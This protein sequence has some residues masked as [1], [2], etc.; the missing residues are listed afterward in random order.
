LTLFLALVLPQIGFGSIGGFIAI[1]VPSVLVYVF[2]VDVSLVRNIGEIGGG[3]PDFEVPS[4]FD[5]TFELVTG[6]VAIAAVTL[7]QGSGISQTVP[8]PDGS[9]R[10]AS[11]DFFGQGIAN[12]ASG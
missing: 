7:V 9:R 2:S 11:R 6:A 1:L 10:H 3:F 8:N 5:V 12:L 4:P